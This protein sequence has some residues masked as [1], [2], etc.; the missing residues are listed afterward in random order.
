[1]TQ[2][3]KLKKTIKHN[4]KKILKDQFEKKLEK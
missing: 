3:K 1:M 4:L 2:L